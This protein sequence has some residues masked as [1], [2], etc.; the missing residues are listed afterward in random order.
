MRLVETR[1]QLYTVN[2]V[3]NACPIRWMD[4][5]EY[6]TAQCRSQPLVA[7][8][9]PLLLGIICGYRWGGTFAAGLCTG[10]CTAGF[11]TLLMA[12]CAAR[13]GFMHF[14]ALTRVA[15]LA[16][17]LALLL[18]L[19]GGWTLAAVDRNV[20]ATEARL[21]QNMAKTQ[22]FVCRVG[23]EVAV[24]PFKG[25][26]SRHVF[27]VDDFRTEN[28]AFTARRLSVRVTWFGERDTGPRPGELWRIRG[29]CRV[30][31]RRNGLLSLAVN[32]GER[33]SVR[34]AEADPASWRMRVSRIRKAAARRVALGIE[35][36]GDIPALNQAMLLGR[37]HEMPSA[38]RRIF[39]D[40]GTIH[41][42]AISGLHIMLV[43][44]VLT[45]T[46]S[47]FGVPQARWVLYVGP[48][49]IFYTVLTGM[50]PSAVRACLM[51]VLYLFAPLISRRSNGMAA[52]AG[53]AL[54]LHVLKPWLIFDV[55]SV[56]S[57]VVMGG[58]VVFCRP[59]CVIGRELFHIE[60]LERHTR[61]LRVSGSAVRANRLDM[62]ICTVKFL[63][64][65][66]AVSLAAFLASMP[67]TAYYFGRFTPGGLIANLFI[68]PCAFMVVVAGCLGVAAS[69]V[70]EWLAACFNH[71]AGFFTWLMVKTAEVTVAIPGTNWFIENW[72]PWLVWTWFGGLLFFAVWLR[73][74]RTYDGLTWLDGH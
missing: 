47:V 30:Q 18:A 8:T 36:W 68:G 12:S 73:H 9:V 6:M 26:S 44:A 17:P 63:S 16:L 49:L 57:F 5:R 35:D 43:A 13:L 51:G 72:P 55:G 48:L 14:D 29:S 45:I 46:I 32:S 41:V 70:S 66:F 62:L 42:F 53:T 69:M 37:R 2:M 20:R 7:I 1:F 31:E 59:F 54:I 58:L 28:G 10:V 19:S 64:D 67:L 71:A 60:A 24:R 65:S 3:V 15:G 11:A 21:F 39:V 22:T 33:R 40:S 52:L 4:I 61:A 34:L 74:R 23:Q 38:M 25:R 27:D 56:L 50:R